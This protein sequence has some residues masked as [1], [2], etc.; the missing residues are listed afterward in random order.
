MAVAR[1]EVIETETRL[2]SSEDLQGSN[3][4]RRPKWIG[5]ANIAHSES[6]DECIHSLGS[7]CKRRAGWPSPV[8]LERMT[9]LWQFS[10]KMSNGMINHGSMQCK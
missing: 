4:P 7:K 2:L 5:K 10:I 3:I 9:G 8:E 1:G 6:L